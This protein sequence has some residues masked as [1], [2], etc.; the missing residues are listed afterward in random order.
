MPK[1]NQLFDRWCVVGL[2]LHTVA[3]GGV[4]TTLVLIAPG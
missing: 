1:L 2:I 3:F 4:L